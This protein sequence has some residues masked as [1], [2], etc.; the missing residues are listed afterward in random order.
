VHRTIRVNDAQFDRSYLRIKWRLRFSQYVGAFRVREF[1][2]SASCGRAKQR[3]E[4]VKS[5]VG[6]V[7]ATVQSHWKSWKGRQAMQR[8]IRH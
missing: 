3:M 6:G 7:R 1:G 8:P 4:S 2:Q 5:R